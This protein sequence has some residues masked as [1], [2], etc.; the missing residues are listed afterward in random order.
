MTIGSRFDGSPALPMPLRLR[1]FRWAGLGLMVLFGLVVIWAMLRLGGGDHSDTLDDAATMLGLVSVPA[2]WLVIAGAFAPSI[3]NWIRGRNDGQDRKLILGQLAELLRLGVP[4]PEA[5]EALAAHQNVSWR[6]RWS[7]ARRTLL[8]MEHAARA[9]DGLGQAMSRDDFFPAY[10]S[11]L[12][13]AAEDKDQLLEVLENLEQT[14]SGRSWFTVWFWLRL[15]M[16][17]FIALP[18]MFFLCSYILPTFVALFE[19]LDIRLPSVTQGLLATSRWFH[20][21]IGMVFRLVPF[22]LLLL[23]V[24]AHFRPS[25]ARRLGDVLIHFPP[26]RQIIP[27]QDQAAV[28]LTLASS[29]RLGLGEQEAV[30]LAAL[31]VQHPAYRRALTGTGGIVQLMEGS[32]HLFAPPLRWLA[33]QG[34]EHGNLAEALGQAAV[35]LS[36]QGEDLKL[37]WS[38]WLDTGITWLLGAFVAALVVGTYL[39]VLDATMNLLQ[40]TILP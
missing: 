11:A 22:A 29:L 33:R 25:L 23:S 40:A 17:W 21:P 31:A 15:L 1:G 20:S 9:G 14:R 18:M 24:V 12:L 6:S 2:F 32:P 26:F 3:Y 39:P 37:R 4:V 16:L 38:I 34:Q 27:L 36:E 13:E 7:S 5:L 28:A 19:G 35:Y 8:I 10:W 30:E